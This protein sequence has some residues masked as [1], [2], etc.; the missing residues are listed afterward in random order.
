MVRCGQRLLV[1]D[2]CLDDGGRWN[3]E[4]E[5]C[6]GLANKGPGVTDSRPLL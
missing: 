3:N 2:R 1:V 4:S 6:E 5:Q